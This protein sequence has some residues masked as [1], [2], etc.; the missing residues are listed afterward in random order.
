MGRCRIFQQNKSPRKL[1]PKYLRL[2]KP[3]EPS[4]VFA[5]ASLVCSGDV[6]PQE[7][8]L[9]ASSQRSPSNPSES[10]PEQV[11]TIQN[12]LLAHRSKSLRL[13]LASPAPGIG[14]EPTVQDKPSGLS[15]SARCDIFKSHDPAKRIL[16]S[17]ESMVRST[18]IPLKSPR[19]AL[20]PTLSQTRSW[21]QRS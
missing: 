12:R 1:A 18:S 2:Y 8:I 14:H 20:S 11:E 3:P 19:E 10:R 13:P 15:R 4:S 17:R 21:C 5:V 7:Y 6:S 9:D 16:N